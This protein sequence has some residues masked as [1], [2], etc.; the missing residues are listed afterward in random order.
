MAAD[1]MILNNES[2][3]A[4]V[5]YVNKLLRAG[6]DLLN[7]KKIKFVLTVSMLRHPLGFFIQISY[8]KNKTHFAAI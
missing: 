7:T 3:T 8:V 5:Y 6:I 1:S 2:K 4:T